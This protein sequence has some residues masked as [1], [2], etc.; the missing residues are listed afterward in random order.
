MASY[1]VIFNGLRGSAN[2]GLWITN[3]T[4]AGTWELAVA[5]I[6]YGLDPGG[7]TLFQGLMLFGGTGT[8][9][10][11]SLWVTDGT[12]AGTTQILTPAMQA[13]A[14]SGLN[15]GDLTV[16]GNEVLLSGFDASGLDG[17]WVTNGT[18]SGTTELAVA[19]ANSTY[20]VGLSPQLLTPVAGKVLFNG[21]DTT[22][23]QLWITDGTAAGT[24]V[25][26]V[27]GQD[28]AGLNPRDI[29]VFGN[30]VL[31]A[32]LSN[33]INTPWRLWV[34]DGTS[35]GTIMLATGLA[36][37]LFSPEY[38]TLLG[39][40]A[41]LVGGYVTQSL[42]VTDGTA[43]GTVPLAVAD[44]SADDFNP[45][46]LTL[47]NGRVLFYGK[48]SAGLGGLWSTDGTAAGTSELAV[49][50]ASA[51]IG[52]SPWY[53]TPFDGGAK[54]IFEGVDAN[55]AYS[56]WITDG[57]AAGTSELVVPGLR[58]SVGSAQFPGY[59]VPGPG[60]YAVGNEVFF[61][62]PDPFTSRDLWVTD[63]TVAGTHEITPAGIGI[64]G[65]DPQYFAALGY[66]DSIH[67]TADINGDGT[68]DILWS[69]A[70]TGS[71]VDWLMNS[72]TVSAASTLFSDPDWSV[73]GSGDFD[74]DGTSD[75][76]WRNAS[77]GSVV[78]WQMN[79]GT[80]AAAA[81]LLDAP[82]WSVA[83]TGDV[84]GDGKADILWRNASTG[85]VV[86][87]EMN[88]F[89]PVNGATLLSDPTWTIAGIGDF[90]G[91]G[92]DDLL[93]RNAATGTVVEWLMND[94]TVSAA[95][96]LLSDPDWT[97]A[98]VGDF[99]GDGNADI[100]W[101]NAATG[102]VAEWLMN[103]S[104]ITSAV[105]LLQDPAWTVAGVGDYA[106][107]GTSDI[108]WRNTGTGQVVEWLMNG[109]T[110]ASATS[111]ITSPTWAPDAALLLSG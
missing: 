62:A 87:W 105:T 63:G 57:T 19:G 25:V 93:W 80:V 7:F 16:F 29:V 104:T 13:G 53:I 102:T 94:G 110:V 2:S 66:A 33:E 50:G 109:G 36:A 34:S 108:L 30:R 40:E 72:G 11:L 32:G 75:L 12:S 42:W 88:G 39:N 96:T 45:G 9:L 5:G 64:G 17:L 18:A 41:V 51:S 70:A 44:A 10:G 65:L 55:N 58:L 97:V 91:D 85:Q 84:N 79:S 4:S 26:P 98:G 23:N 59:P 76:L 27:A 106:G 24:H 69:N 111:L 3:G 92:T 60:F 99:N 8:P 90:N 35:A 95:A 82:A 107:N 56:L 43:A 101:R 1:L 20:G 100:L 22:G 21:V 61:S 74:R 103:G 83:G 48:D 71:V 31:F 6:S 52:V 89:A 73:V 46:D 15:P 67:I 86:D 38:M 68:S 78:E 37:G 77:T 81:G 49:A 54:A 47:L 14:Q 28:P